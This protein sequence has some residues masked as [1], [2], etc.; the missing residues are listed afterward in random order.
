MEPSLLRLQREGDGIIVESVRDLKAKPKV[1]IHVA[2]VPAIHQSKNRWKT[3]RMSP[4]IRETRAGDRTQSCDRLPTTG[5]ANTRA[6]DFYH[7]LGYVDE[8]VKLTKVLAE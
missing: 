5:A 7:R 3:D 1:T 4:D 6:L 8:D 2:I